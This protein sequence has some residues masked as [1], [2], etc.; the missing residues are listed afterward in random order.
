MP[1]ARL[2]AYV[3]GTG[4]KTSVTER[5][6][7]NGEPYPESPDQ[8]SAVAFR[9]M[10]KSFR[11][12]FF[13]WLLC[14]SSIATADSPDASS[15]FLP[16]GKHLATSSS[17]GF[18]RIWEMPSASAAVHEYDWDVEA[19]SFSANGRYLACLSPK[20]LPVTESIAYSDVANG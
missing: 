1:W 10:P 14:F 9:S 11:C 7:G 19:V 18:I 16:D 4:P 12:F 20:F 17:D 2:L 15:A 5:I 3:T 8:G 13:L 6:S